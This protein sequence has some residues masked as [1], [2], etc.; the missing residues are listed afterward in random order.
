MA[1]IDLLITNGTILTMNPQNEILKESTIVVNDGNI[2][3]IGEARKLKG[4]YNAVKELDA[5]NMVIMPGFIDTYA[6]AGH[7]MIKG[8]WHSIHGWP[9]GKM[10]F[11]AATKEF[12][13]ADAYLGA[14]DRIRCGVTTGVSIIGATPARLDV[15]DWAEAHAKAI[16]EVGIRDVIGVGP[17]DPFIPGQ[18]MLN[19]TI[20]E[21]GQSKPFNFTYEETLE[22]SIKIIKKWHNQANG[23][24]QVVLAYPYICGRLRSRA[25]YSEKDIP[26]LLEKSVEIRELADRY[27]VQIHTHVFGGAIEFGLEKFGKEN[28]YKL[29]GPDVVLAHCNS[30]TPK[31]IQILS[32]TDTKV[33][34]AP[35]AVSPHNYGRCPVPELID[36]GVCV[37]TSTDGAAPV[38]SL[39]MFIT[40]RSELRIQRYHFQ[41]PKMIPEGKSLRLATIDAARVL[42]LDN[43][44]GSIEKGK[45][46]DIIVIDTYK[47][48]FTPPI[49]LPQL[50]VY[51]ASGQ[52]VIHT[53]VDGHVLMENEKITSVNEKQVIKFARKEIIK[54]FDR[55]DKL[56]Y[57][58][59]HYFE[60]DDNFWYGSKR[61]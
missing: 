48:H 57:P 59:E 50:L 34:A 41:D 32:E 60:M 24:I 42:Q 28:L 20:W 8:I 39:D 9:A 51:Y 22:N 7:Q 46:A 29:L 40:I 27:G 61:T 35:A 23:R 5:T 25:Q 15:P 30:L 21:N 3:D 38:M 17:P 47:A 18:N 56:G 10:Y 45:K 26:F 58:I 44:I 16:E 14:I 49:L 2:V 53:V 52:D 43:Q 31:E 6:H 54:A 19:S 37:A 13:E 36:S 33:A 12:W 1:D 4:K 11:H 55:L